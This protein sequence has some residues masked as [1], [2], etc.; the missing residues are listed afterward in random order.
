MLTERASEGLQ[1]YHLNM[2][3]LPRKCPLE[4]DELPARL[5]KIHLG[6]NVTTGDIHEGTGDG[7]WSGHLF[8]MMY[9][10]LTNT[11]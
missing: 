3:P 7:N 2:A 9:R 8:G 11:P 1:Y 5:A 4:Q 10:T 6:L